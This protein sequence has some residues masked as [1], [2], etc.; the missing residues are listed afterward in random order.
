MRWKEHFLVPDHTV[1]VIKLIDFFHTSSIDSDFVSQNTGYKRSKFCWILLYLFYEIES[2][3]RRL[4]LSS[5]IGMVS[6]F[7]SQTYSR[8]FDTDI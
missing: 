4:L 2:N 7:E 5:T 8:E 6:I 1:K 3:N